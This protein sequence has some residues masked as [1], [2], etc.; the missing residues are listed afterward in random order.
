MI[1][2]L[3]IQRIGFN[4]VYMAKFVAGVRIID[5]EAVSINSLA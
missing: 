3:E 4:W 1:S 2:E 5:P